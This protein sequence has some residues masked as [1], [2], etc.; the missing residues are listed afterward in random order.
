[1]AGMTE[2]EMAGWLQHYLPAIPPGFGEAA[3]CWIA[4]MKTRSAEH[5]PPFYWLGRAL[6]LVAAGGATEVM[7]ARLE[8]AHGADACEGDEHDDRVQRVLSEA[9]AFGW[10]SKHLGVPTIEAAAFGGDVERER[11]RLVVPELDIYVLPARLTVDARGRALVDDIAE[12]ALAA[13]DL[14]PRA[15][16]RLLYLDMYYGRQYP[17]NVGYDLE[18]TEPVQAAL[19]HYCGEVHVGHVFTRPFQWG[20]PVE[21]HY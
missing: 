11:I 18:L 13:A 16:G 21:T 6:D 20:N 2:M 3:P 7:R 4:R 14:L 15:R 1:M 9:C 19:R 5:N 12:E 17:S 10:T 8:F